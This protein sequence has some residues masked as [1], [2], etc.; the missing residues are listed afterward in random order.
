MTNPSPHSSCPIEGGSAAHIDPHPPPPQPIPPTPW[1]PSS[2]SSPSS[3]LQTLAQTLMS[4]ASDPSHL[5]GESLPASP[6]SSGSSSSGAADPTATNLTQTTSTSAAGD[7][8]GDGDAPTS[9]RVG[10][11]FETEDDAYEFYKAYAARLGFVVR[12]SNKSK[13]SRHTV[14]RRLFVCSK[15]GFRQEPKKPQDE[16]AAAAASSSSPAPPR[17]PDSRTGCLAS[18]TIKLI[19]SANAFR[20]TDLVAEHNHPLASAAPAVSLALLPPSSSHH[21]IAAAASLPDPRDGPHPD[22]HF[23]SEEDAYVFYNRYAEH[24]GFSVRRSYKKRKRGV[25]VSRIFVCSR[26]G[27]SDRAKQEGL[28]TVSAN[29]GVGS[30]GTPRPGPPPTRTGCQARMVIKITPCRTYR[31]AK[32]F[33]EHNHSLVNPESVHK[34]RSHKM[35]ARAHELGAGELHRRKQGKGV[36]LG[37]AGAALQYLEELQVENP[38][39]YY[40]VGVGP[41][42]KSAVNFFWADA[43]SIIDFRTFGDVVLFDT[44]YGLNGYGRPFALFVGV[45]NHK[46]LLVFGAALLYDESIQSLK[47]V[48][49][50]FADAM[51]ARQPQTI[52]IDERPECAIAAAEV[53]PGSNHCTSV[54]H[55]YHN[56]K[57]HLK[58]VFESTKSFG[59]ALSHCLFDCEDEMEFLSSWEKLFEK[60]DAGESEWLNRLFLEKEKWALAY[61]RTMFSADILTTLRKENMI[62][63]LKRELSEQE[64]ILQF[65]RRY[66]TILEEHR[67]KKLHTD[68]DGSQVTLPIPSLRMLKQASN[69]YTPEAFKMFQGEFEAYM[70]CMSFPCGVIGTVSE[71]KIVLDEKPSENFVKFDA[72]DGSA[73]CSCK[74]F[75]A[76]GI[77]CCHVLKVLDLKNIKEL[78]ET[79]IL[80]RWRKDARSVQIGEEPTSGSGSV[81]RSASEAR[82]S[83][84]CR[85][86]S[87]IAS[88]AA[89]SEEAMSYIE[90][91]SSVLLKHRDDMLQIGYPEMG[92][93]TVASSSQAISFVGNQHPDHTTQARA[94]A[95]PTNGLMGL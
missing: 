19:P 87:L 17:C 89:K 68:V 12:K 64:D 4:A 69:A 44:T 76:V 65:F 10:M 43:K 86:A 58:Q 5:S 24:V 95:H 20:V 56:S 9:P 88:R 70:N 21:S 48:F 85:L 62:N 59:N 57:R 71:Y 74:K 73:T 83:N 7:D 32:F 77:Q 30:A 40:A 36:Q 94:V 39:V 3:F 6:T 82:F 81:M 50:V 80:K 90:S 26:E 25:I 79:Y 45:D 37:D 35:R 31:V 11:Y 75:E 72:L 92:N 13:N 78:P 14:T 63:E 16:T 66:E 49:E 38:S 29:G 22:M 60:H 8:D 2:S 1:S 41:D 55:I 93:H 54:W 47:W 18:L 84:M 23:E 34:L 46:Q 53:W 61:Q 28:A 67:S 91:Q 33:P 52:L 42:G 15:Q 27:V 51:R